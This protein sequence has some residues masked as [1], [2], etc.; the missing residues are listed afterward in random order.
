MLKL[1]ASAALLAGLAYVA[2]AAA[3]FFA[4]TNIFFPARVVP[5]AGP[6]PPGAERI[7]FTAPDG[8]RLEGVLIPPVLAGPANRTAI[9]GFAG[10]ASNAAAIAE[11][12][13]SIYPE[14]PVVAFH[15]RGYRPSGGSPSAAALLDDAPLLYDLARQRL[16]PERIVAVGIS[17]GSGVAAG[18]SERRALDGLV[19]VTPFDSLEAVAAERFPWLPVRWLL[20]HNL[21]S[22]ETLARV[23][24][25]VAIVAA[26]HDGVVPPART[27]AL[28]AATANLVRHVTLPGTRHNDVHLHP[29]FRQEMRRALEAVVQTSSDGPAKKPGKGA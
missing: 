17:I 3:L 28:A 4:Q 7:Q 23:S 27:A 9:L 26:E 19:L 20:R 29:R 12:L 10:N 16:R 2:I 8:V 21:P 22:A 14:H 11:F 1:L 15:Y 6:L 18:L 13:G 24:V 5:R 25:P